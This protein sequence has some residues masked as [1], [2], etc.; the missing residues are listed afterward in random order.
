MAIH[1]YGYGTKLCPMK[2]KEHKKNGQNCIEAIKPHVPNLLVI[3][4][5]LLSFSFYLYLIY[6]SGT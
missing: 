6:C 1:L 3:I 4:C 5:I 2:T